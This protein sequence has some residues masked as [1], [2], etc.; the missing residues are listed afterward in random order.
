MDR[1]SFYETPSYRVYIP[2]LDIGHRRIVDKL[3]EQRGIDACP[4]NG[5]VKERILPC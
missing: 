2:N 5:G 3:W 4:L 1:N